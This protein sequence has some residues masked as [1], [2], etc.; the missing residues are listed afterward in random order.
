MQAAILLKKKSQAS[1]K[2]VKHVHVSSDVKVSL[3]F[4]QEVIQGE[5]DSVHYKR[6]GA[7]FGSDKTVKLTQ[8]TKYSLVTTLTPY[9]PILWV[10]P[11]WSFSRLCGQFMPYFFGWFL[12]IVII[13]KIG[14]YWY[15]YC[16]GPS[17]KALVSNF[18]SNHGKSVLYI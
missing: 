15:S 8:D 7:R 10:Q 12:I 2:P 9:T 1:K 11:G 13:S 18:V 6:D 17:S 3:S 4:K 16:M 14:V 5:K